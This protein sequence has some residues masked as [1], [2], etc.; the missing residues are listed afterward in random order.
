MY[1]YLI[2]KI[3]VKQPPLLIIDVGGVGYELF[4]SFAS[5]H[6]MPDIGQEAKVLTHL[7]VRE[8]AQIIYGFENEVERSAFKDLI[9]VN[10]VGPK[11]AIS[12]LSGISP[13]TLYQAVNRKDFT[14][15]TKLPGVGK[16]TAE[17]L[18]LDLKGKDVADFSVIAAT[19]I[20]DDAISALVALGFKAKDA[21]S[22]V[23]K[24]Y[25]DDLTSQ[26]LIKKA[27]AEVN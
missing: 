23:K 17:R 2:G 6:A 15:L 4:C 26:D 1:Y 21:I 14:I 25:A 22:A 24:V 5:I 19:S 7:V 11:L 13:K 3:I 27:L 9:K 10:G 16:K 20:E 12:I 8:D 18:L